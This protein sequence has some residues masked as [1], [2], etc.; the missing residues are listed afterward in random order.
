MVFFRECEVQV[1]SLSDLGPDKPFLKS[2]DKGAAADGQVIALGS[3]AI[4]GH[5]VL[6]SLI[7]DIDYIPFFNRSSGHFLCGLFGR[8]G[9]LHR[10][11][12][13]FVGN[14]GVSYG[15]LKA[16]ILPEGHILACACACACV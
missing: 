14:G 11:I 2:R 13:V 16:F 1:L 3:T 6:L 9:I 8:K 10:F 4:K 15:D 7:I 12:N 5:A